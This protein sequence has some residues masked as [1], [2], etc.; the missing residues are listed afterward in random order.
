M[1]PG[2]GVSLAALVTMACATPTGTKPVSE[3]L[4]RPGSRIELR[5][6]TNPSGHVFGVDAVHLLEEAMAR[7]L[8]EEGLTW[9]PGDAN[10]FVLSLAIRDYRPGDAFKRWL[11]PG[12]GSTVLS[13]DGSLRDAATGELAATIQHR[14]SIHWGGAYTIGAWRNVFGWVAD[15]IAADLRVRILQGGEFV[16]SVTP[17]ADQPAALEPSEDA[18]AVRIAAMH[19]ER[20][21]RGR[22]GER[23]AAFGVSMG[24]VYLSRR[25]LELMREALTDDFWAGGVRVVESGEDAVVEASVRRFWVQTNTTPLYWDVMGEIEIELVVTLPGAGAERRSFDCRQ[26]KRTFIWP[27]ATLAGGVLDACLAE[28]GA[29]LRDDPLWRQPSPRRG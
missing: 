29:K 11:A 18:L 22:I 13:V 12:W 8:Q 19:D 6:V 10:H 24:D 4:P 14:R 26:M 23:Q 2:W 1:R 28:L 20:K 17:R 21:E 27:T 16:I 3:L 9:K 7:S 15:D 25:V 5:E